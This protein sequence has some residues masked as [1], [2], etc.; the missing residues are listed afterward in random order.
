MAPK[1]MSEP[2]EELD[3]VLKHLAVVRIEPGDTL[4]VRYPRSFAQQ[5]AERLEKRLEDMLPGVR[6]IV[7]GDGAELSVLRGVPVPDGGES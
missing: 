6:V 1:N 3:I 7:L 2:T 4:V 5:Y